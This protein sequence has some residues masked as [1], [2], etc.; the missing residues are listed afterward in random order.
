M[1]D[2]EPYLCTFGN[3]PMADH[4]FDNRE[5]W[6][7]HEVQQHRIE[8]CC[9]VTNHPVYQCSQKFLRHM[10]ESHSIASGETSN[11][12]LAMFQ[13]PSKL[14][15]QSCPLCPSNA[16]PT[17]NL[18]SHLGRHMEQVSLF[19]LPR[20]NGGRDSVFDSQNMSQ[21][22]EADAGTDGD[23]DSATSSSKEEPMDFENLEQ[24]QIT[25][26]DSTQIEEDLLPEVDDF[27]WDFATTKFADARQEG[28]PLSE[29]SSRPAAVSTR[30]SVTH[31][32]HISY[33]SKLRSGGSGL[34]TL[35]SDPR[36]KMA[37]E[38]L[39]SNTT[40]MFRPGLFTSNQIY[41]PNASEARMPFI[42]AGVRECLRDIYNDACKG[43]AILSANNYDKFLST[44]Q[45]ET[46][47]SLYEYRSSYTF[48]E[49]LET[50]YKNKYL[51]VLKKEPQR[52]LSHPISNYF[53]SSSHNTYLSGNQLISK[54]STDA[55]KNASQFCIK[56]V[57]FR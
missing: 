22:P 40:M 13:R 33:T 6:F 51:S 27:S 23:E 28:K 36:A 2:M 26:D 34:P 19:S 52:D 15:S 37:F 24:T 53:I 57:E 29:E 38:S 20:F 10:S 45:K 50:M 30:S 1:R 41:L 9:N 42:S 21:I 46:R 7:E 14:T 49:F 39:M 54:S 17:Q 44:T 12:L 31:P 56:A 3:C 4:L 18:K 5:D 48:E 11:Q 25:S 55:Y 16:K 35:M 43:S 32:S 8:W 47:L